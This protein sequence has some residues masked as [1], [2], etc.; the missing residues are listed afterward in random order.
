MPISSKI[1]EQ[2]I[3]DAILYILLETGGNLSTTSVKMYVREL[4]EPIGVNLTPLLN[5]NDEVIDQIVRNIVS[6]RDNCS[7]IISRGYITYNNGL[8]NI[9]DSGKSYLHERMKNRFFLELN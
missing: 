2:D 7:N 4:L 5:R 9:T 6:H 3:T 8:W 1:G